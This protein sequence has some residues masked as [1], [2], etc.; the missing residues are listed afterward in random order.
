[1]KRP[2]DD[3]HGV[4]VTHRRLA[5]IVQEAAELSAAGRVDGVA[6]ESD[7]YVVA[8]EL[9]R[10]LMRRGDATS[11]SQKRGKVSVDAIARTKT[12]L[13]PEPS[14]DYACGQRLLRRAPAREVGRNR[15]AA[16]GSASRSSE[17]G[18][19]VSC[20]GW[21]GAGRTG[22]LAHCNSPRAKAVRSLVVAASHPTHYPHYGRIVSGQSTS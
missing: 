12:E 5:D 20:L 7:R 3:A 19:Q 17:F 14:G 22:S 9:C 13:V 18:I 8:A 21:G 15:K 1:M 16:R 10:K 6:V 4:P 2:R 11:E